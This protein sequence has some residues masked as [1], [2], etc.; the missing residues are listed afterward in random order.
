MVSAFSFTS[1]EEFTKDQKT[2]IYGKYQIYEKDFFLFKGDLVKE[3][4]LKTNTELCGGDSGICES[5]FT[6]TLLKDG[7][8]VDKWNIY[9]KETMKP[10]TMRWL[11]LEYYGDIV[12]YKTQ[13]KGGE[14][15]IDEKNGSKYTEQICNQVEVGSHKDWIEFKEGQ[16]FKSGTYE[17][18]GIGD[19]A[20][21]KN[22]EWTFETSDIETTQWS[23]W[24]AVGGANSWV[25]LTS[26]DNGSTQYTNLVSLTANAS[27]YGGAYLVNATLW[28]SSTGTWEA[29][30]TTNLI[31]IAITDISFP[32]VALNTSFWTY[33]R[34]ASYAT[35]GS[36]KLTLTD[37]SS[38]G[39]PDGQVSSLSIGNG[40]Y[41]VSSYLKATAFGNGGGE[42]VASLGVVETQT[43]TAGQA[44]GVWIERTGSGG[45]GN[46]NFTYYYNTTAVV[47]KKAFAVGTIY[48]L[49]ITKIGTNVSFYV[50]NTYLGSVTDVDTP[51]NRYISLASGRNSGTSPVTE[52]YNVTYALSSKPAS[53]TQ[54]FTN[55]YPIGSNTKWNYQF[56]DTDGACGFATSNRTFSIDSQAP[57]IS[58]NYPTALIDYGYINQSLQLN[59]TTTDTN[60]D[61][62]WYNYNGTNITIVG[63]VS[64]VT[65]LSNITLTTKKNVTIYANDT[66]GNLN[67]TTFSWDYKIFENSRTYNT[68]SYETGYE[69]YS[70][71]VTANSNL[72]AVYL[73][74]N[75]THY[76][77]TDGGN[78][79]YSFDL[80]TTSVGN[81]SVGW[82]FTYGGT[83]ISSTY[84]T[85]Q[86][87][88]NTVLAL[89]NATYP[90]PY[91]NITFKDESTLGSINATMPLGEFSY[92]LGSGSVTKTL[93]NINA[94]ENTRYSFCVS[95][96]TR[97]LNIDAYVQYASSG[98]PQRIWNP[99]VTSYNNTTTSQVL[100]LLSSADG[101]YVTFQVINSVEQ[102]ISNVEVTAIRQISGSDVTVATGTTDDAGTVTFWLNPDFSHDFAFAKTGYTSYST[103]FLPTQTQYTIQMVG[104]GVNNNPSSFRGIAYN[105]YPT[106]KSLVNDTSYNFQF[107]LTSDFWTIT[108]YGFNLRL[109]NGTIITG[110]TTSTEATLLSKAYNTGNQ[111]VIYMDYYWL[112]NGSYVNKTQ[113]WMVFNSAN[114]GWSI[115]HFFGRLNTYLSVGLFGLDDFGR[116]LIIFIIL[117]IVA[118]VMSYKYGLNSPIQVSFII[119]ATVFL[120]D[121]TL[122]FIPDITLAN[123]LVVPNILTFLTGSIFVIILIK[124]GTQ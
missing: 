70:V 88:L 106:N 104:G 13:C 61:D 122:N 25:N 85:Y 79:D 35:V 10:D 22:I 49:N 83:N 51:T 96:S 62:V 64:G 99:T 54:T 60:L 27:V 8:L 29:R 102:P 109:S 82:V 38:A 112:V 89:C 71:N 34:E 40:D 2:S 18:R 66:V 39:A 50:D 94:S 30:N 119:F 47:S 21:W 43:V 52:Y 80:P 31:S 20:P 37:T 11:R 78:W 4:E 26:P 98:Y 124:E 101:L 114:T 19:K 86:N 41:S 28:D 69:T 103:S 115:N 121:V 110:S 113:K 74:L 1:V 117:F 3:Y 97:T 77:A 57:T 100:Y 48:L 59:F 68:T 91:L 6:S 92:Y 24:G 116:Y 90:T 76:Q 16:I 36:N 12:D 84:T 107:N 23:T 87:V 5:Y 9:N 42:H 108:E 32:G 72:T 46:S 105:V 58:L 120:F 111:T 63:A 17:W 33:N 65:N 81:N 44:G 123:G 75:G 95:P 14:T 67:T 45:G 93:Q 53:A 118:G 7:T 55:S 73:N 15:I 56:C